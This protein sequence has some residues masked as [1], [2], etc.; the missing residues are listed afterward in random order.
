MSYSTLLWIV[1]GSSLSWG[2]G[3]W[4]GI[5][6]LYGHLHSARSGRYTLLETC[7]LCSPWSFSPTPSGHCPLAT[8]FFKK[9]EQSIEKLFQAERPVNCLL[10]V[11]SVLLYEDSSQSGGISFER[12]LLARGRTV[13]ITFRYSWGLGVE[14]DGSGGVKRQAERMSPGRRACSHLVIMIH[15]LEHSISL[16]SLLGT[17]A[18]RFK[19]S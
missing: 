12:L 18:S 1:S 15:L 11:R 8:Y 7:V 5:S 19:H 9:K 4:H 3:T 16:H 17:L 10:R 6:Q 2:L 14:M 13:S